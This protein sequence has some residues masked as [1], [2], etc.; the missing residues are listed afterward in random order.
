MLYFIYYNE[1]LDMCTLKHMHSGIFIF[2]ELSID[3]INKFYWFYW[4]KDPAT[5]TKYIQFLKNVK[6]TVTGSWLYFVGLGLD[7]KFGKGPK[8]TT[9]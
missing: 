3:N 9:H 4:N 5:C 7:A 2:Y 6:T 1:L 8:K